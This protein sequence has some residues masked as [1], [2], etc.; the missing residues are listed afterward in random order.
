M[1]MMSGWPRACRRGRADDAGDSANG[2]GEKFRPGIASPEAVPGGRTPSNVGRGRFAFPA[3]SSENDRNR[4][5]CMVP[6][7]AIWPKCDC[8]ETVQAGM[9]WPRQFVGRLPAGRPSV[10]ALTSPGDGDGKTTLADRSWPR[11]WPDERPAACWRSMPTS[12]RRI[13]RGMLAI[14]GGRRPAARL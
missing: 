10:L 7:R 11:N 12:A 1:G 3:I 5:D 6:P 13:S 4:S 8:T 2:I 9:S 14:A